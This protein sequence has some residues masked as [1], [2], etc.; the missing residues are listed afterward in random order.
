MKLE[1]AVEIGSNGL[2]CIGQVPILADRGEFRG[3]V[4]GSVNVSTVPWHFLFVLAI[5]KIIILI[6]RQGFL[7]RLLPKFSSNEADRISAE[8][9]R[10]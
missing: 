3:S 2:V 8:S 1:C 5:I 6:E 10:R 9:T 7:H 4:T